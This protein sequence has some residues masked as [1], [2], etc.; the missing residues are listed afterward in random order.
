MASRKPT[1]MRGA[2]VPNMNPG[3]RAEI[4]DFHRGVS[5]AFQAVNARFTIIEQA[6]ARVI[7]VLSEP[8]EG[9]VP[10]PEPDVNPD[11]LPDA[12]DNGHVDRLH[13]EE[14]WTVEEMEEAQRQAESD[15]EGDGGA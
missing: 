9:E 13:E 6:L 15:W 2:A 7:E 10:A 14:G 3:L 12:D 11:D 4:E 8:D 5:A 1:R